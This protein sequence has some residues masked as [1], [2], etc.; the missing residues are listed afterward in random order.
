MGKGRVKLV[1]WEG[2]RVHQAPPAQ[3]DPLGAA[4][5]SNPTRPTGQCHRPQPK[6]GHWV[7]LP[8]P[9]QPDPLGAAAVHPLN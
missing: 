3:P 9:I 8:S 5:A 4:A 7:P 6:Q 1:T 2:D